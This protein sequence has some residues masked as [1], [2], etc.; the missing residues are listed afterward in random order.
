[1]QCNRSLNI[2]LNGPH[3]KMIGMLGMCVSFPINSFLVS[4]FY[5]RKVSGLFLFNQ[6][7]SEIDHAQRDVSDFNVAQ[8]AV[9]P[10]SR[11]SNQKIS[12]FCNF[13]EVNIRYNRN[14]T[15]SHPCLI[16][17]TLDVLVIFGNACNVQQSV[18]AVGAIRQ[19]MTASCT[20]P[21]IHR[22]PIIGNQ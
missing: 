10:L 19:Q 7:T 20:E 5:S 21:S 18:N 16:Q 1:M 17:G 6:R 2:Y 4:L 9:V 13:Q 12:D 11:I 15:Q 3:R 14:V 22:C 8:P